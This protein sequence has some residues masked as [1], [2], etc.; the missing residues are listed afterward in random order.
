M[1]DKLSVR[2]V[3]VLCPCS[4][5]AAPAKAAPAASNGAPSTPAPYRSP[6]PVP[7]PRDKRAPSPLPNYNEYPEYLQPMAAYEQQMLG[8]LV[9]FEG[10][11]AKRLRQALQITMIEP[12]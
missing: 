7:I 3:S 9:C 11:S 10:M 1:A 2:D 12:K 4:H 5:D 6:S 8:L